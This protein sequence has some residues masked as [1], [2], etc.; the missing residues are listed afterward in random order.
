M[1]KPEPEPVQTSTRLLDAALL[2]LGERGAR[3]LTVRAVEDV[4]RV[5]HGSIRHHFGDR[6]G[7]LVAVFDH[8]ERLE[9]GPPPTDEP[10]ERPTP[11]A[12]D[13]PSDHQIDA[14]TALIEHWLGPGRTVSLARYE[15]FLLAARDPT[16][17]AP[18][19][20]ARERF[21]A[22][23]AA[24]VGPERA[25]AV[26]AAIDGVVLDALIRGDMD[27][28]ALRHSVAYLLDN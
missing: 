25:P 19:V 7:L 22:R 27:H 15:L 20:R 21:V 9:A 16:L 13:A 2:V 12:A 23:A 6:R 28:A 1:P 14:L 10:R 3:D 8:L 5:P 17:R 26:V 24:L 11:P 18:L 4:A